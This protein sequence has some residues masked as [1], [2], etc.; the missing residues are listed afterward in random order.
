MASGFR[1]APGPDGD[2]REQTLLAVARGLVQDLHPRARMDVRL[3]SSLERELGLDSLSQ[4]EL[5]ARVEKAFDVRLPDDALEKVRSLGDLLELLPSEAEATQGVRSEAP[6]PVAIAAASGEG[7]PQEAST[8]SEVLEWHAARHPDQLHA[9]VIQTGEPAEELT[10]GALREAAGRVA[11]GLR[12]DGVV[13][14]DRVAL[15]LPTGPEYFETFLGVLLAGCVPVPI[16]PPWRRTQLEDH[17][18][19]QAGILRNAESRVLVTVP[20]ARL[21]ARQLRLNVP[22]LHRV[23]TPEE[24]RG[25]GSDAGEA[26]PTP[27]RSSGSDIAFL[28]YTSGSTGSPKGV[29][30]TH[31]NLLTNIRAMGEAVA[32]GSG[33]VFVSWLPLYH[34]MGL[35]GAWLGSL[36][37]GIPLVVMPPT[38]FLRH[39]VEWLRA[40]HQNRGT[41]SASPNFGFELCLSRIEE[42]ELDGLD[43]SSWRMVFNG[44][45]PVSP[46]TMEKFTE[47]FGP[48]GFRREAMAPVYG[49]AE[50]SLG[51]TFP[52]LGRGPLI[53]SIAREPFLRSGEAVPAED[54]PNALRFP[55]CGHPL[56]GH[57]LRIVDEDRRPLPERRQGRI[58]FRGPSATSGYFRNPDATRK[59]IFDGWLDSGDLGYLAGGE[60]FV[61]GRVKDLIIRVGR[62][63]H[64][65]ELEQAVGGIEGVRKGRAAVFG[66]SDPSSGTERMV[67]V[68]E[69]REE[70]P[71]LRERISQQ[72]TSTSVDL[73][74]TPP[75]EV[76]LA[77]PGSVLKTS[78]GKIRR[79]E[80]RLLYEE[81]RLGAEAKPLWRQ[82][83][84]LAAAGAAVRLRAIPAAA[85]ALLYA[86]RAWTVFGVSASVA[87]LGVAVIPGTSLRWRFFR[88]AA[89]LML[90]LAGLTPTMD[91]ES[92]LPEGP[93][94]VVANHSSM[95]DGL[96]LAVVIPRRLK[97]VAAS[98]F[99]ERRLTGIFLRRLGAEFV[100]RQD[101]G[102]GAK[103][104]RALVTAAREGVPLVFF[105]EGRMSRTPGLQPFLLGAFAVAAELEIP[106]VPVTIRGPESILRATSRFPRKGRIEVFLSSPLKPAEG[107]WSGAV[108]LRNE[109]RAA[110]LRHLSEPDLEV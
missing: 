34:D 104:P 44:A 43:L 86:V 15:M 37:F 74:G 59:L 90:R 54:E 70:D 89:R 65:H 25:E 64:P 51:V 110:I 47:R 42:G 7:H 38:S 5:L 91:A 3:G 63:I 101:R 97:F 17:L 69:T 29:V 103:A 13:P 16:Y 10:Y 55:S 23:V 77:P 21:L 108:A 82:V 75:D 67:V 28:Q 6:R 66:A 78:S 1:Q 4:V 93:C 57:E 72:I 46:G 58:E 41:L 26:G 33:D 83:L 76:V 81:G 45:E 39:P 32:V 102:R 88:G 79:A 56:R 19:R 52:P 100:D 14:G 85:G 50:S 92:E 106:V 31:S 18:L 109:A 80:T 2:R 40:I 62:N 105:P 8:W 22:A 94:V 61:T 53:D 96:I 30:L 60:L 11:A 27:N 73:L 20:E 36:Y 9:R 35:I 84:D 95:L 12:S 71:E 99:A 24:V 107:G 98:E 48:Y 68:A 87:W 49:L